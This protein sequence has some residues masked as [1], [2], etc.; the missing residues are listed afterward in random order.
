MPEELVL[1]RL[2]CNHGDHVDRSCGSWLARS[3]APWITSSAW[4]HRRR[5]GSAN[6]PSGRLH[7]SVGR[8]FWRTLSIPSRMHARMASQGIRQADKC[9]EY[10]CEYLP[11]L[12]A[13]ADKFAVIFHAHIAD[14]QFRNGTAVAPICC[15]CRTEMPRATP[16]PAFP[17]PGKA[18]SNASI[19][20][21]AGA[22]QHQDRFRLAGVGGVPRTNLTSI[23]GHGGCPQ[24]PF[25]PGGRSGPGMPRSCSR[26]VLTVSATIIPTIPPARA[27]PPKPGGTIARAAIGLAPRPRRTGVSL[28]RRRIALIYWSGSRL[29]PIRGSRTTNAH[30][31]TGCSS[32]TSGAIADDS[33]A[34]SS[35]ARYHTGAQQG[36]DLYGVKVG[37]GFRR[38][39]SG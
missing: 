12:A 15:T 27:R 5:T 28:V 38:P 24:S 2:G 29:A 19:L 22:T 21:I 33:P 4:R 20:G 26:L 25:S 32:P 1:H 14:R 37:P 11:R 13:L 16:A 6:R 17:C 30:S 7:L 34:G 9:P 3:N 8:T 35:I 31:A 23:P 10:F 18:G 36:R 39:T